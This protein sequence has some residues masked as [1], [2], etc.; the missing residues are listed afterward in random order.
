MSSLHSRISRNLTP[1]S[2]CSGFTDNNRTPKVHSR[3]EEYI[4]TQ[5]VQKSDLIGLRAVVSLDRTRF[6]HPPRNALKFYFNHEI[7]AGVKRYRPARLDLHES[8]IIGKPFQRIST[9]ICF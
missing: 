7:I 1:N 6:G 9:A 5:K 4:L 8:G 2:F 3:I